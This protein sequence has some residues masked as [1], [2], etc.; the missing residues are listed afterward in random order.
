MIFLEYLQSCFVARVLVIWCRMNQ[1]G[2]G[3]YKTWC[4]IIKYFCTSSM[5]LYKQLLRTYS[6]IKKTLNYVILTEYVPS[7]EYGVLRMG[8]GQVGWH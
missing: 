7:T 5:Y 1:Y 6:N 4:K 3:Y 8:L 2:A